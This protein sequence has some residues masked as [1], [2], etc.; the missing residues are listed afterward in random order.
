MTSKEVADKL[1]EKHLEELI[2]GECPSCL[3]KTEFKYVGEQE[4]FRGSYSMY[5]CKNCETTIPIES[6]KISD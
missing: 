3:K 2:I 1:N 6:I 4:T 5:S